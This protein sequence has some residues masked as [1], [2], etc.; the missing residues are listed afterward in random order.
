MKN[1]TGVIDLQLENLLEAVKRQQAA[2]CQEISGRG[3]QRATQ[4]L[5]AARRQGRIRMHQAVVEERQRIEAALLQARGRVRTQR[6]R[7][8]QQRY[9]A[10]LNDGWALLEA[11]LRAR[12]QDPGQRRAWCESL[13]ADGLKV[14]GD[15]PLVIEHP[16]GWPEDDQAWLREQL[17]KAS[18]A[19][20]EYRADESIECGLRI[21]TPQACLDGTLPGLLADRTSAQAILLAAWERA[22]ASLR[23]GADGGEAH[24]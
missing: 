5:R 9:Q 6:R 23:T 22:D 4:L 16:V 21:C 7:L 12:W 18:G 8:L 13:L 19:D 14:F 20:P 10:L 11:A 2:R 15:A 1:F 3:R 17:R 24:E